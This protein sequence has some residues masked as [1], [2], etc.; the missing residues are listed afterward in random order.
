MTVPSAT[1]GRSLIHASLNNPIWKESIEGFRVDLANDS[2]RPAAIQNL[3][4]RVFPHLDD[5]SLKNM[6]T[7]LLAKSHSKLESLFGK[8]VARKMLS[9]DEKFDKLKRERDLLRAQ[10]KE[11]PVKA[12]GPDCLCAMLQGLKQA[13]EDVQKAY[14]AHY[15]ARQEQQLFGPARFPQ[16][17]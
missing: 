8:I 17:P 12:C 7:Y 10:V 3:L 1:S 6:Q 2:S 11:Q 15:E 16:A 14:Q 9:T 4:K 5:Q 13:D